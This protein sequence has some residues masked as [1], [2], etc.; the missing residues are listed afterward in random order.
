MIISNKINFYKILIRMFATLDI[1]IT[2]LNIS[3]M[4]VIDIYE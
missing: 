1:Y 3:V 2:R 4:K